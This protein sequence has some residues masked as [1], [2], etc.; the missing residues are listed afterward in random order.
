[1]QLGTNYLLEVK[2]LFQEN[3]IDFIDFFKLYS[4]NEDL[5]GM[6]WCCSK[7]MV[8]FHGICGDSSLFGDKDLI[9]KTNIGATK[10]MIEKSKTPYISGHISTK[11]KSQTEEETYEAFR[12]NISDFKNMF[13]QKIALENVPFRKK[14][15]YCEY[16]IKPEVIS[17]IV[18]END[19]DFIFDLSHARKAAEHLNMSLEEYIDKLP[20]DRVVEFHLAGMFDLPDISNE[21]IRNQY[22]EMQIRFIKASEE[23]YGRR[24]DYHGKLN[25]EDYEFL[26]NYISRYPTLQ[27]IT[28][29]Y[30][31]YN[32]GTLFDDE[33]FIYPVAN[34]YNSNEKIKEEVYT[35]LKRIKLI[36]DKNS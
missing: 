21:D 32:D 12:K 11:N 19:V 9:T 1:M 28:L 10:N 4:L 20:M 25:E 27:Y 3:K 14:R 24:F 7:K 33:A 34:F 15:A 35:Q 18:H 8:M 2:E 17:Q 23:L 13:G 29:E 16:L 26:E 36:M 30:G 5:S 22:T 6:D 31:S